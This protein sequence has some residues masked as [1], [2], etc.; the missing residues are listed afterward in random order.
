MR[1]TTLNT[2]IALFITAFFILTNS[3]AQ[4]YAKNGIVVS[5]NK[6]ASEVGI[7]ILEKK[8]GMP[9]MLL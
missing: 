3:L 8:V 7:A 6:I 2:P 5:D 4:T 1:I 9:S